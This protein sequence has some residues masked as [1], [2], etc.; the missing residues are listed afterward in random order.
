MKIRSMLFVMLSLFLFGCDNSV[1][2]IKVPTSALYMIN[3][4]IPCTI[5]GE[6]KYDTY[7]A[8][9]NYNHIDYEIKIQRRKPNI[10]G[11][12]IILTEGDI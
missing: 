6:I 3:G 7:H 4:N 12:A 10:K 1:V 11:T 2:K 9:F 8:G 5:N